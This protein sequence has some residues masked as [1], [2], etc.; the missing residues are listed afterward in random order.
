MTRSLPQI[1]PLN[2]EIPNQGIRYGH[3]KLGGRSPNGD[4]IAVNSYTITLNSRPFIVVSGEFQPTRYPSAYWEEELLKIKAGGI[5][6]IASYLFWIH[7]EE[8]E[9]DF[10]WSGGKNIRR[11]VELV[12]KHGLFAIARIARLSLTGSWSPTTT[13][14]SDSLLGGRDRRV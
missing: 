10:D 1:H 8:V 11:F 2:L 6:T 13:G 5:N 7:H 4:E 14:K 9:G 12:T 3:L